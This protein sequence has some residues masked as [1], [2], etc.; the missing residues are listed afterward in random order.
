M[1]KSDTALF[2]ASSTAAARI[3]RRTPRPS[4]MTR[5]SRQGRAK[6]RSR[7]R[8]APANAPPERGTRGDDE[9]L[10]EKASAPVR[11]AAIA[12]PPTSHLPA[13]MVRPGWVGDTGCGGVSMGENTFE[14]PVIF[15]KNDFWSRYRTNCAVSRTQVEVFTGDT[16]QCRKQG[17][18][19]RR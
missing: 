15:T 16:G 14:K 5:A 19:R 18:P 9:T 6:R 8:R 11:H 4:K 7:R 1:K 17:R 13:T 10:T 12:A 2:H 3:Q